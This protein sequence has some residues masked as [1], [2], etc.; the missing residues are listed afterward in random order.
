MYVQKEINPANN[1]I[2]DVFT[3][4]RFTEDTLTDWESK[5]DSSVKIIQND[6]PSLIVLDLRDN[7]GGY[8]DGA[9]YGLSDFLPENSV[10][11]MQQTRDGQ[12]QLFYTQK[13]Q[14]LTNYKVEILVNGNTA[15]AAEIFSGAL[16]YYKKGSV[17]GTNTYGKGTAQ[18]IY[19]LSD[20]STL[21]VTTVHWLLPSSRWIQPSNSIKPNYL[22]Q[23][24]S[25]DFKN[26]TDPQLLK[27]ESL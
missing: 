22:V 11:A 12:K 16:Q 6:N 17:I 1:K 5:W 27:A 9:V 13:N 8:F 2:V 7:P 4:S 18:D 3:V 10:A 25:D 24:S 26:G 23:Y 14:R 21:H 19:T 15:S 20:G